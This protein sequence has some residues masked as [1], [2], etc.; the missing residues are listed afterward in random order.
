MK[1]QHLREVLHHASGPVNEA[2]LAEAKLCSKGVTREAL[3]QQVTAGPGVQEIR[4][5]I[6]KRTAVAVLLPLVAFVG[7]YFSQAGSAENSGSVFT[8]IC[9]WVISVT[10]HSIL[11]GAGQIQAGFL[12]E[13][14][15][16]IYQPISGWD[17]YG[18]AALAW[19]SRLADEWRQAKIY[20]SAPW[21][22][23]DLI[24]MEALAL[25][26]PDYSAAHAKL[27]ETLTEA[28]I[29]KQETHAR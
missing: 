18:I 11:T 21:C 17:I 9:I 22:K 12:K 8:L 1:K 26:D 16:R 6:W 14:K 15:G 27:T 19:S 20:D 2:L 28:V 5:R 24:I 13:Q 29:G 25:Q 3:I 4:S 23:A 10:V 7:W